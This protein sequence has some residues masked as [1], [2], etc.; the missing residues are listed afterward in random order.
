MFRT[1]SNQCIAA[2]FLALS[3][4]GIAEATEDNPLREAL[5]Q[6]DSQRVTFP[7]NGFVRRASYITLQDTDTESVLNQTEEVDPLRIDDQTTIDPNQTQLEGEIVVVGETI[8]EG[9]VVAGD[10]ATGLCGTRLGICADG[11]LI[12]CP[13]SYTHLT[14]PTIYS[15]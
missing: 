9:E 4:F 8:M 1:L 3:S 14:L 15:V 7:D 10:C 11:C 5:T 13:V 12:P 6:D 2:L